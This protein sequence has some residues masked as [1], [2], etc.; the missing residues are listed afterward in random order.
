MLSIDN[1]AALFALRKGRSKLS[2]PF[3]ELCFAFWSLARSL[4]LEVA[5]AWVPIRFNIAD[6]PS[7]R[8]S[9]AGV[10]LPPTEVAASLWDRAFRPAL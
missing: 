3:N 6:D 5:V 4:C 8:E 9:P 7:R 10:S 2:T 1:S